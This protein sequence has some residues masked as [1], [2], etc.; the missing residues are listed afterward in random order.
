MSLNFRSWCPDRTYAQ[1][2]KYI[3]ESLGLRYSEGVILDVEGMWKES[4]TKIPMIC[5]L[6]MGSDPTLTID[7]LAKKHQLGESYLVL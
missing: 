3:S 5:L 7:G 2:R 4:A 1:A 6:S